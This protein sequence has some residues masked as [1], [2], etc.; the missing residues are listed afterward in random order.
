MAHDYYDR[1]STAG[2]RQP[3]IRRAAE[4]SL[5]RRHAGSNSVPAMGLLTQH[6][7]K[8]FA[9]A[10]GACS[11][12]RASAARDFWLARPQRDRAFGAMLIGAS[13]VS[14]RRSW[15]GYHPR[16]RSRNFQ[17]NRL[18][19]RRDAR[20]SS[21]SP[22]GRSSP[23]RRRLRRSARPFCRSFPSRRRFRDF[24]L[25]VTNVLLYINQ[26]FPDLRC[27][28]ARGQAD[29]GRASRGGERGGYAAI[30]ALA[31]LWPL[32]MIVGGRLPA[33]A[34][35]VSLLAALADH[36]RRRPAVRPLGR[37]RSP[38][39]SP[40]RSR[41]T[42]IA[43]NLHGVLMAAALARFRFLTSPA[44]FRSPL[45]RSQMLRATAAT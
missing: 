35:L 11:S 20:R 8:V 44:H 37:A 24:A 38:R 45:A 23:S 17:R 3:P 21:R 12:A 31:Y 30:G 36:G 39:R 42:I 27:R 16:R 29:A 4:L 28:R 22:A 2:V 34:R 1:P 19:R 7:V 5:H 26:T 14:S 25:L 43:A 9:T 13:R 10:T 41:M 32:A 33:S 15:A 40:R 18:R 6:E